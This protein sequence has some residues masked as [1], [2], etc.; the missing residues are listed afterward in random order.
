MEA[1]AQTLGLSLPVPSVQQLVKDNP[2]AVPSR[3]I[4]DGVE[5]PASAK[6]LTAVNNVPVIDMQKL[7]SE[8]SEEFQ[9]LHLACKDW[10]FFHLINHGVNGSLVEEVKREIKGFFN[11]PLEEKQ[12]KYGQAEGDTDGFG[13]LFVVSEEQKLDWADMF[14]LKTLPA[15]IRSPNVFPKLP[16]AFRNTIEAYSVE[17]HKLSMKVLCFLAKNL[18][19]KSEEMSMLFEEGMQSMRMNYY[20]PCPQSELVMGLSPHS[21]AGG[22][23][24]LLQVNETT[25]LEIKKDGTWFP[26]VPIPNAFVVNVGDCVEIF[27][28]GIY[29][30]IEHR[31]LVSTN[32]VRISIATF[33]SPRLDSELGP[34]TSLINTQN[35]AKFKRVSVPDFFRLFFGRKLEG[36]SH[37]DVLRIG[38][39]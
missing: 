11:L 2:N 12:S 1:D 39:D 38:N 3:Y 21:D 36:K 17:M 32:K 28:N 31:A 8:D 13:Q 23:T 20:P 27:S 16:E 24:I 34:S 10:G 30:S 22:L 6:S 19:I 7:V 4:R 26:V 37:V 15:N 5:S 18:G 14:Y 35:S 25:G 9:K 29:R 33:Q